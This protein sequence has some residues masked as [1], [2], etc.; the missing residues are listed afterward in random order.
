MFHSCDPGKASDRLCRHSGIYRRAG[1]VGS[2][3]L[4]IA[5]C[6]STSQA[7][8]PV[9]PIRDAAEPADALFAGAYRQIHDYYLDPVTVE[10]LALAGIAGLD[11]GTEGQSVDEV[12]GVVRLLDHGSERK[13]L[14]RPEADDA[15]GWAAVTAAAVSAARTTDPALAGATDEQIYRRIFD[16]IT[17][18]LDRFTR[19]AG[20]DAAHD[21]RASRDG[22]GGIGANFDYSQAEP[23]V[24]TLL[25]D[26]PA[27]RAG[28]RSDD[29]VVAIDG[30]TT[31]GRDERDIT[32]KLAGRPGSRVSLALYRSQSG[33]TIP[34]IIRRSLII[35]MSVTAEREDGV[36]VFHVA[37]FNHDTAKSLAQ[38]FTRL[39]G[40]TGGV[41]G[42][43][44]DLRGNPG[45]LLDQAVDVAGLFLDGG[46]IVSEAGRHPTSVQHFEA[47]G[48]DVT[49]GLPLVVLVNGGSA[50]SA[51]IVAAALQDT[52]RAVV[53]GSSSYG[54]GT[55]QMVVPL[56]NTGELTL[57]WARLIT[58]SGYILHHHGIVPAFCT[59]GS[60]EGVVGDDADRVNGIIALG[61]HPALGVARMP[62]ASLSDSG[63]ADLRQSCPTQ[64]VRPALDLQI[65]KQLLKNPGLYAQALTLPGIAVAHDPDA[66]VVRSALQ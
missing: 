51:E 45:G 46:V 29:R 12:G 6:A 23:R 41:S 35:P 55:V 1:A 56:E 2:L 32:A 22:F 5:A 26:G 54:K 66:S 43:V 15:E 17:A 27:A 48:R 58:P 62:R 65:A 10:T 30:V 60:V 25:P 24:T 57:T 7:S 50:S 28:V 16:G 36:A 59:S 21:Q 31:V 14:P 8:H 53:V 63:W 40:E 4:L 18:K 33:R 11:S 37:G 9:T 49:H 64:T 34:A 19:Y 39:H 20:I 3:L 52:G 13:R 42:I 44:L 47:N 61:L 38:N